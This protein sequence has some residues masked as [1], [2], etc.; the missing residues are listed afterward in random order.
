MTVPDA[1]RVRV[2]ATS[3]N[4]GP[5][6]D[7]FGLAL[8]LFDEVVV[9]CAGSGLTWNISGEGAHNVRRGESSL[10]VRA[11]RAGMGS[12]EGGDPDLPGLQVECLNRIPHSRGMGSSAAAVVAGVLAGRALAGRDADPSSPKVLQL[13][14]T[15]EGHPDNVAPCLLGGATVAWMD[16]S[17]PAAVRVEPAA[18]LTAL[19][20]VPDQ[21]LAT[22]KARSLL[23]ATVPHADAAHAA[24]RA[25]LLAIALT[26]RPDLL[27]PATEDRL[28]QPH[29]ASAMPA[30]AEL[31]SE[32]RARGFPAVIS[33]AGPSVL[34]L[35]P[36]DAPDPAHVNASG[37]TL[38]RFSLQR[39][40][41]TVEDVSRTVGA[42]SG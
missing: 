28:H 23:P 7:A 25:G 24:G 3:A 41:A 31:L 36:A 1:V 39:T 27:L 16:G 6:F 42:P 9:R 30:T 20:Y 22:V 38:R 14:T 18:G 4:L 11:I 19:V 29:R 34:A 13:A 37:F 33:G 21:K 35:L 32:L 8:D 2:P 15:L 10:L 17:M 5:G 26:T 12:G 40:G